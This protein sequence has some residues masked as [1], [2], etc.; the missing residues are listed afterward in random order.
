M[1]LKRNVKA[2]EMITA[3]VHVDFF[4]VIKFPYANAGKLELRQVKENAFLNIFCPFHTVNILSVRK[5]SRLLSRYLFHSYELDKTK[6]IN[7]DFNSL[8]CCYLS[9]GI[10]T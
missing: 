1:G 8:S 3:I 9:K 4:V 6:V 5:C 7:S 2:E 10:S